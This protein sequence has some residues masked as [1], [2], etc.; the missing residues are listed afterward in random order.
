MQIDAVISGFAE[1]ILALVLAPCIIYVAL[2]AFAAL[3]QD[4]DEMAELKKDNVV[5]LIL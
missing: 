1:F 3:T 5:L 4:I 2:R